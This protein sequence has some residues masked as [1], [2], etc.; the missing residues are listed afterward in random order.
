MKFDENLH[1]DGKQII[2][3]EDDISILNTFFGS[4]IKKR[5]ASLLF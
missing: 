3:S 5:K 2:K 4:K 1:V